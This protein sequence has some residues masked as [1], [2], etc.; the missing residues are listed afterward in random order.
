[1]ETIFVGLAIA[2]CAV[3]VTLTQM[4]LCVKFRDWA[5]EK[6]AFWKKLTTCPYCFSHWLAIGATLIVQLRPVEL[7]YSLPVVT[8]LV[9]LAIGWWATVFIA[10]LGAGVL[11]KLYDFRPE[12]RML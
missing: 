1:M 2:A 5:E 12:P 4:P 6:G 9:E 3:T 8:Y 10:G 11:T 7:P